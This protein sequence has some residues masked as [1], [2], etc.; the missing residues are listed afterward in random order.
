MNTS[1]TT[2]FTRQTW[3][4]PCYGWIRRTPRSPALPTAI[5]HLVNNVVRQPNLYFAMCRPEGCTRRTPRSRALPS[6]IYCGQRRL[7]AHTRWL[8]G[9]PYVQT[10][11]GQYGCTRAAAAEASCHAESTAP[12]RRHRTAEL[13]C[14]PDPTP[15]PPTW[16]IQLQPCVRSPPH[17]PSSMNLC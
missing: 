16:T 12:P 7:A 9:G 8:P 4:I 14:S 13:P 3:P 1:W 10:L 11:A 15:L 17:E 2:L 6:P 5:Y